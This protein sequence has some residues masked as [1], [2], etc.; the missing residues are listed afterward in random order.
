MLKY[1]LDDN[2]HQITVVGIVFNAKN[3]QVDTWSDEY[4]LISKVSILG[5]NGKGI[6]RVICSSKARLVEVEK[7]CAED[8]SLGEKLKEYLKAE[9]IEIDP[10]HLFYYSFHF[11]L[12]NFF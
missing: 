2:N 8:E 12:L 3:S 6:E 7:K 10:Q 5:W 11:S 9:V 1:K 4:N